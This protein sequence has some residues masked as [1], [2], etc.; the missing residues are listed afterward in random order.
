MSTLVPDPP[1]TL[2][3]NLT[4]AC[5]ML[6]CL[7]AVAYESADQD[8]GPKRDLAFS[9]VHLGQGLKALLDRSLTQVEAR[10]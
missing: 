10:H 8:S 3:Q 5:D 2:E 6:R 7:L 1:E 9:V 4:Q